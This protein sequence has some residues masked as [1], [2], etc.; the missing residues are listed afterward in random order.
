MMTLSE[1]TSF[2]INDN[3]ST[4]ILSSILSDDC[5]EPTPVL[6]L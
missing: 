1:A 6:K 4:G 3:T 2:A 5:S